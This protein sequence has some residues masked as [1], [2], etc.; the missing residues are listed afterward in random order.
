MAPSHALALALAIILALSYLHYGVTDEH[1]EVLSSDSELSLVV[2]GAAAERAVAA[3][4]E[5]DFVPSVLFGA[6][7]SPDNSVASHSMRSPDSLSSSDISEV[8]LMSQFQGMRCEQVKS[9]FYPAKAA[10][11]DSGE[12]SGDVSEAS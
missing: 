4:D 8:Y 3:V 12:G 9:H 5:D 11:L 10:H 2:L 7:G 1:T 6:N